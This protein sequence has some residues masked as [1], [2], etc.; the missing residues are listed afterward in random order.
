MHILIVCTHNRRERTT[1]FAQELDSHAFGGVDYV[2]Q[3]D[4]LQQ[5]EVQRVVFKPYSAYMLFYE[6]CGCGFV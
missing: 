1:I 5:K 2:K 3:W 4:A 6:V